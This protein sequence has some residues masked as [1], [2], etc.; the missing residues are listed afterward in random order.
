MGP[1]GFHVDEARRFAQGALGAQDQTIAVVGAAISH[2][3]A[4]GATDF[5]SGEVGWG[6]EL[7]FGDD[8]GFVMSGDCIGRG[9]GKLVRCDEEGIG[10]RVEHA[11]FVEIWSAR[12]MNQELQS[13]RGTEKVEKG[14]VVNE[15]RFGL[16][17]VWRYQG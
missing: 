11:G 1:L 8:N 15:K 2:I 5:V 3:V 12:V 13:R 9:V 7:D 14:V 17:G 16:R 6:K 4:L 10:W